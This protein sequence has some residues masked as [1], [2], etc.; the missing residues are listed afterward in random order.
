M[1]DAFQYNRSLGNFGEDEGIAVMRWANFP[2]NVL[3]HTAA[4]H[5]AKGAKWDGGYSARFPGAAYND[6]RGMVEALIEAV[7]RHAQYQAS[8]V[9]AEVEQALGIGS[10]KP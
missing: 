4:C 10:H 6:P 5:D 2:G 9:L 3:G 7:P 8:H 1:E